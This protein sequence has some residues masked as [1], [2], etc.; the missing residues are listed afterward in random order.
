MKRAQVKMFESLAVLVVFFFFLIFGASFYFKLQESSVK[1][2]MEE[3]AQLKV[4]QIAQ[5]SLTLPELECSRIGVQRE[6]CVDELKARKFAELLTNENVQVD[7]FKTFEYAKV[8]VHKIYPDADE[9]VIYDKED[10]NRQESRVAQIPVLLYLPET[11]H[12][13]FGYLEVTVFA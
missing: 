8:S 4:I 3:N 10:P 7:Y 13:A 12:Y 2:Q 6:N 1:R 9:V 11:N 5:K